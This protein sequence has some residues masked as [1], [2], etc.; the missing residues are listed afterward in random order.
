MDPGKLE[1]QTGI[2]LHPFEN[3][4]KPLSKLYLTNISDH[5]ILQSNRIDWR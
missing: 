2:V 1:L 4:R 3:I 5:A